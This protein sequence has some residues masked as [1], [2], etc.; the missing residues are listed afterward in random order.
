MAADSKMH[1][2]AADFEPFRPLALIMV[3]MGGACASIDF[4][5]QV[6]TVLREQKSVTKLYLITF[7]FAVP[8]S[9]LL[10]SFAGLAGAVVGSLV[11]MSILFI[12]L[13]TEYL[14][15]KRRLEN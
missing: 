14:A 1:P 8:I 2:I 9:I 10:V 15:I 3:V 7:A 5:Y 12:L 6:I 11:I 4:L 13:I